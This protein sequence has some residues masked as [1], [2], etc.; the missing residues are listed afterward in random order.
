MTTPNQPTT[1]T[2]C[3]GEGGSWAPKEKGQPFVN[4]CQMCKASPTYWA[5][6]KPANRQE[7]TLG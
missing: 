4:G 1:R 6:S 7:A 2:T 3:C 5:K